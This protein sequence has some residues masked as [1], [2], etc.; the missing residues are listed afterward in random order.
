[1]P[2]PPPALRWLHYSARHYFV[3]RRLRGLLDF[4]LD[5]RNEVRSRPAERRQADLSD[6]TNAIPQH[7]PSG[8][9]RSDPPA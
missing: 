4:L 1:M 5:S 7:W 3:R 2:D 8:G 6:R 9:S